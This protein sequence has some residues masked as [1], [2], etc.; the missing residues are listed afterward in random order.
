MLVYKP[1]STLSTVNP[2]VILV[3]NQLSNIFQSYI[4]YNML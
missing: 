4:S 3:I 2:T 1:N